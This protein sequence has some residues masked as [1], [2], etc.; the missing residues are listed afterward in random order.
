MS[1]EAWMNSSAPS[2]IPS[3]FFSRMDIPQDYAYRDRPHE[4]KKRRE[5]PKP[6]DNTIT[7]GMTALLRE[8]CEIVEVNVELVIR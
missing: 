6:L 2:F 3:S 4:Q 5:N 7:V 8:M 1:R